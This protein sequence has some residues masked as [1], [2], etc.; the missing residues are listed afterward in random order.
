MRRF[1]GKTAVVTGASAGIGEACVRKLVAEGA[2]VVLAARGEE[3]LQRL[4]QEL[5][6]EVAFAVTTDVT[7]I[8]ACERLL[9]AAKDRFGSL[10]ILINNAGFNSRGPLREVP[11]DEVLQMVDANLRAPALLTRLVLPEMLAQGSGSI[12]NVASLAGRYPL[13]D[14]A[15]YS[16]AKF[17]LRAF[18]FALAEE[19]RGTGVKISVV[20]PGPVE[21]DFLMRSI[22]QVPDL[23]FSQEMSTADEIADMVLQSAFDGRRE[24]VKP[25][26][27]AKLATVG[28]LFPGVRRALKPALQRKGRRSKEK[29]RA[30]YGSR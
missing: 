3:G 30:R 9:R 28:Y 17:G 15:T 13:E 6:S 26:V 18:S 16:A 21:T 23:T 29:Y 7:D 10:D 19:L 11:V 25:V 12:V 22:D 4:V 2:N 27:G 8:S 14:D 1:E 5:G 20:S 24:R